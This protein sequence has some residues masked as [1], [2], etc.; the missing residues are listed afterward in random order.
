M[1]SSRSIIS[2]NC[3]RITSNKKVVIKLHKKKELFIFIL[4][5]STQCSVFERSLLTDD[6]SFYHHLSSLSAAATPM[7]SRCYCLHLL[8]LYGK[9]FLQ[10]AEW[11]GEAEVELHRQS[12]LILKWQ[13]PDM[14]DT[15]CALTNFWCQLNWFIKQSY[16]SSLMFAFN[17]V[18]TTPH[19]CHAKKSIWKTLNGKSTHHTSLVKIIRQSV[20]S[21]N[22]SYY[23]N[24][25]VIQSSSGSGSLR[26]DKSD[27]VEW[28]NNEI[29]SLLGQLGQ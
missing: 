27:F 17:R 7:L 13:Q 15:F 25:N 24:T 2:A 10:H 11:R 3:D 9:V 4:H 28:I 26:S 14:A 18:C 12:I 20:E 23:S 29:D 6:V 21:N 1:P 19:R 22:M 5:T 8:P 16:F